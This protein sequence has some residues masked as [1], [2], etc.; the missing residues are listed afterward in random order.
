[1]ELFNLTPYVLGNDSG[2]ALA[3]RDICYISPCNSLCYHGENSMSMAIMIVCI[4][5][6]I[7]GTTTVPSIFETGDH[8][9]D[10]CPSG[11]LSSSHQASEEVGTYGEKTSIHPCHH[12]SCYNPS[13]NTC[14]Q[15]HKTC[16]HG[17]CCSWDSTCRG[18]QDSRIHD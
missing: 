15:S 12:I 8:P 4:M 3:L 2:Y 6:A 17:T 13:Y 11:Q 5:F 10:A 7:R 18:P 14:C 9:M 16:H 1:M